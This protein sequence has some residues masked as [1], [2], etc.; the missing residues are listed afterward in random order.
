MSG[1]A[2]QASQIGTLPSLLSFP[3]SNELYA[4]ESPFSS[5]NKYVV[6]PRVYHFH[7]EVLPSLVNQKLQWLIVVKCQKITFC[8]LQ[9]KRKS[10]MREK[11][12]KQ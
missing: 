8:F 6:A 1:K 12:Q 2:T 11:R 3:W 10:I 7:I 9:G 5:C 4:K